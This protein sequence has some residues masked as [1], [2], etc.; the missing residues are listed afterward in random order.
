MIRLFC[1]ECGAECDHPE[2]TLW[3]LRIDRPGAYV[4][5]CSDCRERYERTMKEYDDAVEE[6]EEAVNRLREKKVEYEKKFWEDLERKED[7]G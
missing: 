1:D 4:W 2:D 7:G 5:L 3:F 6:A